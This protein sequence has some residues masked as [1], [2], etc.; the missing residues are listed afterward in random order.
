MNKIEINKIS[1]SFQSKQTE[2]S[3]RLHFLAT[4]K[5][6][7]VVGLF[8]FCIP[9]MVFIPSD[10]FLFGYSKELT[11]LV[12]IRCLTIIFLSTT[13]FVV[14][15]SKNV[16]TTDKMILASL[17]I[18]CCLAF[19]VN[20]SRPAGYFQHSIVDIIIVF[21]TY[22][23][24]PNRYFFQIIPALGLTVFNI[25]IFV[26]HKENATILTS[27]VFWFSYFFANALG[28]WTS[29]HLHIYRRRQFRTQFEE[30]AVSAKLQMALDEIKT[31]QGIIPI[32]AKCKKIRDDQGY[33]NKIESYIESNTDAQFTHSICVECEEV[34]YGN[35]EWYKKLRVK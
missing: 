10:Y 31:L 4:D 32:C 16:F 3:Y 23:L 35:D 30:K 29:W 24:I 12:V 20:M 17:L 9:V 28:M 33:W 13:I 5:W 1:A 14:I 8:L 11:Q 15:K 6:Q 19:Y 34:L 22:F 21:A 27:I 7:I 26:F 2:L 18:C 25:Y